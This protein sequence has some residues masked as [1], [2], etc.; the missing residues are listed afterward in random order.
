MRL[1]RLS[2]AAGVSKALIYAYFPT[3]YD[4]FNAVLADAF[5]AL[6]ASGLE[7]ASRAPTL[8]AAA[9]VCAELYFEQV[10]TAGPVVHAILRDAFM[11]ER[12]EAENRLFR[13]R[14]M[15][16]LAR[17]VRRELELPAKE[18]VAALN[19]VVT[20]PE[21]AGRLVWSGELDRER[22]RTLMIELV[23]ASLAAF[24]A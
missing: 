3:Q 21:Q 22:A 14:I 23:A 10:A 12:I 2:R 16:R 6:A 24:R 19:L 4:L 5:A 9:T 7:A 17:L 15:R 20:I 18:A 8:E 11:R 1:E 13:D